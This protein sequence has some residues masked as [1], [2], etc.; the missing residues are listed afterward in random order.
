MGT[1]R[2]ISNDYQN[3]L[4]EAMNSEEILDETLENLKYLNERF[5]KKIENMAYIVQEIQTN[6]NAL[7]IEIERLTNR[8]SRWQ[9]NLKSIKEYMKNEML[10]VGKTKINTAFYT[11]NI[12]KSETCEISSE[13]IKEAK[14]KNL[15]VLLRIIP[16]KVEPDK[17]AI[18][19]YINRGFELKHAKI[20]ENRNL[21]I[22]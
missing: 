3:I 7:N 14:E 8:I 10:N 16:E 19:E 17:T 20:I 22:R 4:Y 5:D 1:L 15:E 2:E 9:K 12:R 6:C 11:V 18:K 21:I 13:F